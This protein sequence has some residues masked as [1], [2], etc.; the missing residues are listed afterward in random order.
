MAFR[1][2]GESG[3]MQWASATLTSPDQG[4][5]VFD[6]EAVEWEPLAR[7]RSPSTG[8]EYPVKWRL[9]VGQQRFR[10]E[11]LMNDAELDSRSSTGLIYWE[12]PV[13]LL[14]E[15]GTQAGSGYLEM[16]GYADRVRF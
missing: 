1:M 6:P 3:A 5:R 10:V 15:D 13:R 2:R 11:P 4:R 9:R 7:W 12:G 14:R 16:T 8:A